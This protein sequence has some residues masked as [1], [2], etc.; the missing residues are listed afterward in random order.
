MVCINGSLKV[1][2]WPIG[3][4]LLPPVF[5]KTENKYELI[6]WSQQPSHEV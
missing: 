5:V 2:H 6:K 1:F 3:D 4:K